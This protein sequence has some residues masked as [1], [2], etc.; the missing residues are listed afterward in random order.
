MWLGA[1][2]TDGYAFFTYFGV[3]RR[4]HRWVYE[5]AVGPIPR[6]IYVL[7]RCGH[8]L[9][10]RPEHLYLGDHAS[11]RQRDAFG[12][13]ARGQRHTSKTNPERAVSGEDH[14]DTRLDWTTVR[15]IRS[16]HID[17]ESTRALASTYRVSQKTVLKITSGRA[18]RE[19]TQP[20]E[21][22]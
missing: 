8:R 19:P 9:C 6:G 21:A 22:P 16:R 15:R 11:M 12:R 20:S 13:T 1:L 2:S 18:W 4:A 10:M 14:W 17:G 7:H 5:E 3:A